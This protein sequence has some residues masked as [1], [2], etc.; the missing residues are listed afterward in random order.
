MSNIEYTRGSHSSSGRHLQLVPVAV[1][2]AQGEEE[3]EE[4]SYQTF[5]TK[6]HYNLREEKYNAHGK[7]KGQTC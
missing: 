7:D 2:E 6:T 5:R 4:Q 3:Q 1:A